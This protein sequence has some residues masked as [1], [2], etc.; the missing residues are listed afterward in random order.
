[1]QRACYVHQISFSKNVTTLKHYF[2]KLKY[3]DKL[4]NQ[5]MHNFQP[6]L[7]NQHNVVYQVCR[8]GAI[9][10]GDGWNMCQR[11]E[12]QGGQEC[13]LPREILKIR[14]SEP[15]CTL[16]VLKA[17]CCENRQPKVNLKNVD[18]T[19]TLKLQNGS[20]W[21]RDYFIYVFYS[22]RECHYLKT[23]KVEIKLKIRIVHWVCCK[24]WWSARLR[25]SQW[26]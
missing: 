11:C 13:M 15:E 5:S 19:Q 16:C 8:Q 23:T 25:A 4:I 20:F 22:F 17:V 26:S 18:I 1:V 21:P 12:P 14:L 9:Q 10:W 7:V 24:P 2:V 3:P 6:A